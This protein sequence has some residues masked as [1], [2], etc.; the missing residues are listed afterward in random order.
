MLRYIRYILF[1]LLISFNFLNSIPP[2]AVTFDTPVL[3]LDQHDLSQRFVPYFRFRKMSDPIWNGNAEGLSELRASGSSQFTPEGLKQIKENLGEK[4]LIVVD[5]RQESHGFVNE[6]PAA[7]WGNGGP[8]IN[9][10]KDLAAIIEHENQW[11]AESSHADTA[12]SFYSNRCIS[13]IVDYFFNSSIEKNALQNLNPS[14]NAVRT[15]IVPIQI[16]PNQSNL[17]VLQVD[18]ITNSLKTEEMLCQDLGISYMRIP[19]PD[20]KHPSNQDVDRF[21]TF[22]KGLSDQDWVHFH[23]A[24]GKGR[25]TSFLAM[26]DMMHNAKKV[27]FEEILRRQEALGGANLMKPGMDYDPYSSARLE[28]LK[29]FYQY[30]VDNMDNFAT[31]FSSY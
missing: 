29:S 20:L 2:T 6:T 16:Y 25:T 7:W 24:A 21:I 22:V 19:V 30:C 3:I 1:T 9:Q 26:Y 12:Y 18:Y 8:W 11:V 23:C 31:P 13:R 27:S 4:H 15:Y 28:F 5:L 14:L 10:D 17:K